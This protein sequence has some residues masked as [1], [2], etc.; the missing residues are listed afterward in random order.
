MNTRL[1]VE[2][3]VTEEAYDLDLVKNQ[4]KVAAGYKLDFEKLKMN[5]HTIE[6]RINAENAKD[7]SPSPGT[8][9]FINLPGGRGVRVDTAL[10]SNYKVN[11]H[12]DSLI[13]KLISK[14]KNRL[15]AISVMERALNEIIIDG[16]DTNIDLHKWILKQPVFIKGEYNTNWLE[17]NISNFN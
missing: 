17:K 2:H 6:C 15:E 3:P 9:K 16:I 14:G 7:F 5:N 4:I 13:L 1:Q 11:P 12:Y 8:I 10:Y